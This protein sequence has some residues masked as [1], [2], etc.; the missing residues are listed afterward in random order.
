MC[1]LSASSGS[2]CTSRAT[3][4]AVSRV[5]PISRYMSTSSASSASGCRASSARSTATSPA[6]ASFCVC[7]DANSP[8]AI[9]KAPATRPAIPVR[10]I[11]W[12]S[13]PP[14]P[15]P[16]ISAMLVTSPSI[17]PNVAARNAPPET[18]RWWWSP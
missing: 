9:E 13:A 18:S 10:M 2:A 3:A 5:R 1:T 15:T 16:A 7:T 8:S 11:A 17:A 12:R 14:P 6:T 4:C